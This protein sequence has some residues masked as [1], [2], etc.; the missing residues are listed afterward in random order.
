[1]IGEGGPTAEQ[2]EEERKA[3]KVILDARVGFCPHSRHQEAEAA[4][5]ALIQQRAEE[6]RRQEEAADEL[7]RK[8]LEEEAE[9]KARERAQLMPFILL[10][11]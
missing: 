8:K 3:A 6:R 9:Q 5:K 10:T 4:R 2:L 1:M 7:A 11:S